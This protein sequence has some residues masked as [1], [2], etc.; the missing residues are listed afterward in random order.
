MGQD[1][2]A[3]VPSL[4]QDQLAA[5]FKGFQMKL[6]SELS[7]QRYLYRRG[8]TANQKRIALRNKKTLEFIAKHPEGVT[9]EDFKN[10]GENYQG[11]S[12]LLK[13]GIISAKQIRE[14]ERGPRCFHWLWTVNKKG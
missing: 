10:A 6:D 11:I 8:Q 3:A 12:R 1:C 5:P 4:L 9:A 13:L 14:P 2:I 7:S